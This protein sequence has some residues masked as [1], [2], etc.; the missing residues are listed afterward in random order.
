M[1]AETG[2]GQA[3]VQRPGG[4]LHI[5]R[6]ILIVAPSQAGALPARLVFSA[7]VCVA[8]LPWLHWSAPLA[9]LA[10]MS[11]LAALEHGMNR[12]PRLLG[13]QNLFSWLQSA[14]YAAAAFYLTFLETGAAQTLG[15]T[16]FGVVMFEILARDYSRPRRLLTNLTPMLAAMATVQVAAVIL[17]LQRGEGWKI[18]TVIATAYLVF[19]ALRSVQID[20]SKARRGLAEASARA[21]ADARKIRESQRLAE[22]TDAMAGVGHWRIHMATGVT[23]WSEGMYRIYGMSQTAAVPKIDDQMARYSPE[24]RERLREKLM[25]AIN[26]GEPFHFEGSITRPD[27]SARQVV[28]H[29]AAELDADGAVEHLYGALMDVTEAR[30][31][32]EALH[33]AKRR[34][35]AAAEAKAE[36]LANMS[37]EIRTPLTAI[38]GF[39][40]LLG[41]LD[42]LPP[43][44]ASYVRRVNT[45]GQTLLAVVNDI[46]DFSKLEAGQIATD[47]RPFAVGPLVEDLTAMFAEQARAKGLVLALEIAPDMPDTLETDAGRLRQVIVN[48]IGNAIKFTDAGEVRIVVRHEAGLLSVAVSDTGCGVPEDKRDQLFQRFSQVDGSVSRRHGGTGLGL[49]ICKGLV[50]L[51]GGEI[52]MAP[53]PGGGSTFRFAIPAPIAALPDAPAAVDSEDDEAA[54]ARVLV[55]DDL[56]TNRELVRRM[57]EAIGHEV[58]EADS[59]PAALVL[60]A[61]RPYHLILMDLQMP[62]MDGFASA[63]AIRGQPSANHDTPII[64]LSADVLPE[65][66]TAS[67]EAG[68]NG[69]L[70][71]P[72]SPAE[73][74]GAVSRWAGVRV[75]VDVAA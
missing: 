46:L 67:A 7:V 48:L 74:I 55:V 47:L 24:D 51:L 52:G 15:V 50:E 34:A 29:G 69:H 13:G 10:L 23:V 65:H 19:R 59:G 63:R 70:G 66:I 6:D 38:N 21:G 16:L 75:Q 31:R 27:G 8:V 60:A 72:I 37:H 22:L 68:M 36:F 71:K 12:A 35:E 18:I 64:A 56:D 73:L 9:W 54:V 14:G 20:L 62:G 17:L 4:P 45:A 57:L 33:D 43:E 49:S 58:E 42:G 44:A 53:S 30:A 39:S 3:V 5:L 41:E 32:E 11:A 28:C 1:A 40:A 26:R 2:T 25:A 61:G